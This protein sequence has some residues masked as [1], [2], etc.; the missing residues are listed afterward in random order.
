M[1][2]NLDQNDR[3]FLEQ[4]GRQG[5]ATVPEICDRLGVTATAVRQRLVRLRAAGFIER[6]LVRN[7]RGRPHHAYQVSSLGQRE[8]GDNYAELAA[9][10]WQ[11]L[12]TIEEPDVRAHLQQRIQEA[13]VKRYGRDVD[14]ETLHERVEQLKTALQDR[15]FDVEVDQ[16]GPLPVLRERNCPYLELAQSDPRICEMEQLVYEKI[17]G[18]SVSLTSCCLDGHHCCEFVTSELEAVTVPLDK[19]SDSET[20]D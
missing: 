4:L 17:L 13:L 10:L 8:L 7:G 9:I 2:A 15:G 19:H 16:T 18:S 1:R 20:G 11:E 5:S 6:E 12:Q 3:Q 14:G